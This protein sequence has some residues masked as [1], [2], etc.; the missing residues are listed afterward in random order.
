MKKPAIRNVLVPIDFSGMSI[1]A[2][3]TAKQLAQRY[4]AGVHLTHVYQLEYLANFTAPMPPLVPFSLASHEEDMEKRLA[5]QLGTL[6]DEHGVPRT[7]CHLLS[8][9]PAFDEICRLAKEL[10]ADLIVTPTHGRTGLTHV[11]LGS[12]AERIVQ[13]SPCP[14]FVVRQNSRRSKTR[15]VSSINTVLVPVD[16]SDCSLRGLEYAVSFAGKLAA[17]VILVHAMQIGYPYTADGYALYDLSTLTNALQ[18]DAERQMQRF[19]RV[20]RLSHAKVETAIITGQPA[21]AI[22]TFARDRDVD[23]II[24]STH[25]RT[26]FKHVLIGSTAEQMVRHAPCPV[27]VVPSHLGIRVANLVRTPAAKPRTASNGS[28]KKKSI[29]PMRFTRKSRKMT[30]H[31]FPER[32]KTN[33]FRESHPH[34]RRFKG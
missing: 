13:H 21:E 22:C 31:P 8:G 33:K 27:L 11:F 18:R 2:I 5:H 9:A 25:G 10:P 17:R 30:T 4:D 16:F 14:V 20:S 32:R 23:L 6:G 1:E 29:E 34:M 26:G 3:E 15:R 12:T 19:V 7:N 24:T 28:R